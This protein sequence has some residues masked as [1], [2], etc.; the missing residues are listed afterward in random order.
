MFG[1]RNRCA[2]SRASPACRARDTIWMPRIESTP[3][4]KKLSWTP[5]RLRPTRS[6]VIPARISSAVVRGG[7]YSVCR[8]R[9]PQGVGRREGRSV[10]LAV[11]R[12]R[13][14]LERRRTTMGPS[15]RAGGPSAIDSG[16]TSSGP[17]DGRGHDV[18]G[19][20]LLS[21]G[22]LGDTTTASPTSGV[23]PV[24]PQPRRARRGSPAPSPGRLAGPAA[25]ARLRHA[26]AP[27]HPVAYIR[28]PGSPCGSGTNRSAV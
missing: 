24:R 6:A 5:T 20:P 16:P 9:R 13:H 8:G 7:T 21:V 18:G 17:E 27:G 2:G 23:G 22:I 26:I 12:E 1:C 25:R 19:E 4:S 3:I 11:G 28:D 10:E 14:R 15:A